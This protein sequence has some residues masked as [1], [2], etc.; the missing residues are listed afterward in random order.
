[1]APLTLSPR[2]CRSVE[3]DF[4]QQEGRFQRV[5]SHMEPDAEP[6][7]PA[8]APGSPAAVPPRQELSPVTKLPAKLDAK[9]SRRKCF[10]FL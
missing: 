4:R 9:K 5:L 10:W 1:M 2:P 6:G 8:A 7:S 3:H